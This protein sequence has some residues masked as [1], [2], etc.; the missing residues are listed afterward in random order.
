MV[1]DKNSCNLVSDKITFVLLLLLLFFPSL[2]YDYT[3]KLLII[4]SVLSVIFYFKEA[5]LILKKKGY[6]I[7][8]INILFVLLM[9]I[10][11]TYSKNLND[12]IKKINTLLPVIIL[13]IIFIYFQPKYRQEKYDL[14]YLVFII[15]NALFLI[16]LFLF[17]MDK[18]VY[19][20]YYDISEL[21]N[22]KKIY[23]IWEVPFSKLLWCAEQINDPYIFIHKTYNS[24]NLLVANLFSIILFFRRKH[25][26]FFK[27][28][29]VVFFLFFSITIVYLKS[30]LGIF[31]LVTVLPFV[32]IYHILK[33]KQTLMIFCFV[34]FLGL[35]FSIVNFNKINTIIKST[36]DKDKSISYNKSLDGIGERI[37]INK[38]SYQLLKDIPFFG[39]GVG[40][41]QDKLNEQY[42]LNSEFSFIYK[43]FYNEKINSHNYYF[44]LYLGGGI[45][46]L[47]SFM[48]MIYFNIKLSFNVRNIY[49][50]VFLIFIYSILL[51]ENVLSRMSGVLTYSLMNSLFLKQIINNSKP[52][53]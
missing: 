47:I 2:P 31:L 29:L 32:L 22:I 41:I 48:Y 51:T 23:Y 17:I 43:F 3:S 11:L 7:V 35:S 12:G 36:Q 46:L 14:I 38:V 6:K 50:I 39:Y 53:E 44:N 40:D 5:N 27:F 18:A 28:C 42:L 25:N 52:K 26:L 21:S 9:I 45:V 13:P 33:P 4:F 37:L 19:S 10:T 20:C 15:S 24:I 30:F 8:L 34:F 49:Y 1:F 16:I